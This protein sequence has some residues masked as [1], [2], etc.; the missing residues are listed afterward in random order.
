MK[1]HS[2]ILLTITSFIFMVSCY[3]NKEE[4]VYPTIKSGCDT[5]SVT[6]SNHIAP[7]MKAQC[8]SCHA[9]SSPSG[10]IALN[11][12]DAVKKSADN[13]KL[14]GSINHSP[15]YSPMPKGK[16]KLPDCQIKQVKIWI[17]NG[18]PNN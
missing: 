7:I 12:Y 18:A 5:L 8:T 9:G 4:E 1:N 6:Y 2:I 11:T 14:Y 10:G 16:D 3:R 15:S 13:G 17:D